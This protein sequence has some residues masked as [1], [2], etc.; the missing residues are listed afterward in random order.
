MNGHESCPFCA[1]HETMTPPEVLA[2]RG[3]SGAPN[4]PGWN[5][6]VV[7]NKFPALRH[8]GTFRCERDGLFE[9]A[10]GIG[11]HEVIVETP[12]HVKTLATMSEAEIAEVLW[13][14][15][16]RIADL[17]RDVRFKYIL[18]FKNWGPAAGATLAHSHSQLMALPIVPDFVCEEL[19]GARRHH[20]QTERCVFCD[21]IQVELAIGRRLVHE[22]SEVVALA[23]YAPRLP[24]ETWLL[25]RHHETRFED[26]SGPVYESLA[27]TLKA[28]LQRMNHALES[29]SY[30]LLVHTLPISES[31]ENFYHWHVEL[32]PKLT[33][34][35]GF[36]W[37]T[38]FYINPTAP[39]EAAEVLRNADP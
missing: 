26:A 2:L 32:M 4:T 34:T 6:R 33:R 39:E 27:R 17:R 11:A 36:E 13:A 7:P 3:D 30:N 21:I 15:R 22:D 23:P 1:G 14:F 12:D 28:V 38:G 35:A 29:P 37:G 24:F 16:A 18:V 5:V 31:A 9:R 20:A 25:P 19:D 10:S 8:D